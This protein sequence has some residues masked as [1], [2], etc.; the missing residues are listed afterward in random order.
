ML[1]AARSGAASESTVT[2]SSP[3]DLFL[4]PLKFFGGA[5]LRFLTGCL[6][7]AGCLGWAQ[8]NGLLSRSGLDQA[9]T[10]AQ[11]A[12][13]GRVLAVLELAFPTEPNPLS[14]PFVGVWFTSIAPGIAGLVLI[15]FSLGRSW[16]AVIGSVLGA[17]IMMLGPSL[18]VPGVAALGGADATSLILGLTVAVGLVLI[19]GGRG[20]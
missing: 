18:G 10:A 7:L 13:S 14:L 2:R 4:L 11:A 5:R 16:K 6:L 20:R 12:K 8:Q 17:T 19:P 15:V 1:A 9:R 3:L